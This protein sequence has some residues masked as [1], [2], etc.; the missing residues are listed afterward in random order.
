MY[1]NDRIALGT[2]LARGLQDFRGKDAVILCLKESS[3]LTCLTMAKELRAWV[4]PL[5]F[6]PIYSKDN[7]RLTLGA[8]DENGK[9]YLNPEIGINELE[10]LPTA[11]KSAVEDQK[12]EALAAIKQQLASYGM[13]FDIHHLDG[14]D[15]IIAGD[16]VTSPLP[17]VVAWQLLDTIVPKSL[18]IVVGNATPAVADLVRI[19][20]DKTTVL[21]VLSGVVSDDDHYFQHPD[22]YSL[23]E[24][25]KLTQHIATYWQ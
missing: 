20:G 7:P 10:Q 3:L 8:V 5:V 12:Q 18:T 2:T 11:F 14:R 1:F 16:I 22:S 6:M 4:Y 9:S 24:K 17:L 21:D 23:E 15:V 25:R 13:E 19:S